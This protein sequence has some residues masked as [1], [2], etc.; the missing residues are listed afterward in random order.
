MSTPNA[1]ALPRPLSLLGTAFAFFN[2]L[3]IVAYLPTLAAIQ[4]SG[5][6]DQHSLFTWISFLG[7]NATMAM[8]LF[9][10]NGRR[11][12]RAI[13]VSASNA[14]MCAAIAASIVWLRWWPAGS[15]ALALPV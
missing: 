1:S 5:G 11:P 6:A 10:Q 13:V 4:S 9:E 15:T 14:V 3:R 2:A 12:N 8:W 7:A